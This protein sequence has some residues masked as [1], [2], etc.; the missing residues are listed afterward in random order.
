MPASTK[1]QW[2]A[3]DLIRRLL[4][5]LDVACRIIRT[6]LDAAPADAEPADQVSGD[7]G[8][9]RAKVVAETAML[10][11]CVEPVRGL[12][13]R[14]RVQSDIVTKLLIPHAR[15]EDVL[16]A[17]CM[18]PGRASDHAVA[19]LIL[20]CLGFPDAG[21]DELLSKSLAMGAHFG[22]E[23]L[24]HRRLEQAWLARI[25]NVYQAR[26]RYD[27]RLVSESMLG[28][29][30]DALGATRLDI[31]A[32]THA[33][34]YASDLGRRAIPGARAR[35]AI[36]ADAEASLALCLDTNDFDLTAEVVMTWPMLG[37]AWSAAATLH[38]EF[39]V[40]SRTVSDSFRD[41]HSIRR[42]TNP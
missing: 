30:V 25:W 22:P 10:L 17:I 29:P 34:M 1:A 3:S 28:G 8:F 35:T 9:L 15:H 5:A 14:I 2:D 7:R 4:N 18:D 40:T 13:D 21:V 42:A 41:R 24:P 39:F 11:Y 12:D 31:Y 23:R 16:A 38:S 36:A 33:V 27:S 20:S 6:V 19:H 26:P 37:I 32:F